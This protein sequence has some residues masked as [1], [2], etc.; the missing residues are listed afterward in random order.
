M[1]TSVFRM[2]LT[3]SI[4]PF[5]F[6][7]EYTNTLD[8]E[9]LDNL[10]LYVHIPFCRT[11]CSFCP[12]CKEKYDE[13][14]AIS[15]K[16]ALLKEI[17]MVSA[18][19]REK[20]KV[21]TLYFG[22]GTPALMINELEDIIDKFKEYFVIEEGIAIELHPSDIEE[23]ILHRLKTIGITMVSIGMQSFNSNCLQKIGRNYEDFVAKLQKIQ[24]F[25]FET[26]DVDLIFGIPGQNSDILKEDIDLAFNNG[27]TQV[28]TYPFI[29][30]TFVN[31]RYKPLGHRDKIYMLQALNAHCKE[32]YL[33]KTA[34][35]TFGKK[36]IARYSSVTRDMFLGF[37]VSATTL[38]RDVFKINTFS[39]RE[40]INRM[41]EGNLPTA[42]TLKFTKRQRGAYYLFWSAYSLKIDPANFENVLGIPLEKMFPVELWV[43]KKLGL[44]KKQNEKIYLTEKASNL[45]H[46]LEQVYTTAY[47]DKMWN[48][49]RVEAFPEE[50]KLK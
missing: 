49:M 42:L 2:I 3:R 19:M 20:K 28:S 31:N 16:E 26:V 50:I 29:D 32:K 47:I 15:Y 41:K 7:K 21:T 46:Y 10:G 11:L 45:Y 38:L 39:I 25:N 33:E 30:F 24:S 37:G 40:Y 43:G 14:L 12:Y 22:G 13:A 34:V 9:E 4:K 36:G 5:I 48:I 1:L 6:K 8:F 17:D 27:A 35:W 44:L 18:S 23:E